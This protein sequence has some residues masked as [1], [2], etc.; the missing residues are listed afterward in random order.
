MKSLMSLNRFE[1]FSNGVFAYC[2]AFVIR[3]ELNFAILCNPNASAYIVNASAYIVN[4]SI[5]IV[6]A[7]ICIANASA[8]I[9]NASVC[10]KNATL[11]RKAVLSELYSLNKL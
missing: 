7:S 1:T 5:Y 2:T 6:N 10:I 11:L 3:S 8:C 9:V 4:A